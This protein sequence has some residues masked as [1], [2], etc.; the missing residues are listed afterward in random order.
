M[1]NGGWFDTVW[2]WFISQSAWYIIMLAAGTAMPTIWKFFH[3]RRIAQKVMVAY[4][5]LRMVCEPE[6]LNPNKP[7]NMDFMKVDARDRVNVLSGPLKKAGFSPPPKCT[8]NDS[9]LQEWYAFMEDVRIE[10]GGLWVK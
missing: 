6:I 5:L 2:D 10:V 8:T 4:G 1:G 7:G 3:R 9:S